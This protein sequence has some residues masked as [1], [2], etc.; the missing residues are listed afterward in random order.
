MDNLDFLTTLMPGNKDIFAAPVTTTPATLSQP[1]VTST[2]KKETFTA[3]P[4]SDDIVNELLGCQ[5]N[6]DCFIHNLGLFKIDLKH[7][8]NET[9]VKK[10]V[11]KAVD[12]QWGDILIELLAIDIGVKA[13]TEYTSGKPESDFFKYIDTYLHEPI[14]R[15]AVAPAAVAAAAAA[16]A[17]EAMMPAAPAAKTQQVKQVPA[18]K[19]Q[20]VKQVPAAPAAAAPKIPVKTTVEYIW[21]KDDVPL[22]K[23]ILLTGPVPDPSKAFIINQV[24]P[25]HEANYVLKSG[26]KLIKVEGQDIT[27]A[28]SSAA[29]ASQLWDNL[30]AGHPKMDLHLTFERTQ[31][32]GKRKRTYKKSKRSRMT[33]RM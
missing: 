24:N 29:A 2:V 28:E 20:Q 27:S 17:G 6:V 9:L 13:Y 22:E 1:T 4:L 11:E 3:T 14:K 30:V 7:E 15:T 33:R 8:T 31:G 12:L 23:I 16:A 21:K 18:A 19:A 10:L 26:D 25:Q 5:Q 32:G